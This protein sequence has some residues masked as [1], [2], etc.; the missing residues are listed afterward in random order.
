M[1]GESSILSSIGGNLFEIPLTNHDITF[2]T[3]AGQY[4][5]RIV[6][7]Q[8]TVDVR[9]N[10]GEQVAKVET[11]HSVSSANLF[12]RRY[13]CVN[14]A[15]LAYAVGHSARIRRGGIDAARWHLL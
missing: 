13:H 9:T 3:G 14:F 12:V 6:G 11:I 2:S 7:Q 10:N 5:T 4:H 1:A 15:G 8:Q